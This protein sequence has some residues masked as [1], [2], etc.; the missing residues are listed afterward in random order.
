MPDAILHSPSAYIFAGI[1]GALLG[2]FANVCILRIPAGQSIVRPGSHCFACGKPVRFYDNVPILSF[3]WL[4]GRCRACGARFSPRY[5]AV[6]A[7]TAALIVVTYHL[8]VAVRADE[9][10]QTRLLRFAVYALF[11]LV[12][13]VI[14]FIDLDHKIVP[15]R[16]T[17]PGIPVF[18]GLGILLRDRPILDLVLGVVVGYGIVRVIADGWRLLFKREGM[19]YGDGKLLALIGGLLGWQA[20]LVSIFVGSLVGS[21]VSIPFLALRRTQG[22]LRFEVPFGPFLAVA[23]ILFLLLEGRITLGFL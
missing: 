10:P 13:V 4:R 22:L 15:D 19:G 8:T 9:E 12:L 7:A 3:L 17:Y 1:L 14:S 5:L 11:V 2:S 20:V 6:E 21:L 23:A 16:I 18:L